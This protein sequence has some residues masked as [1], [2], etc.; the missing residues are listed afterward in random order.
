MSSPRMISDVPADRE[1]IGRAHGRGTGDVDVL[2]PVIGPC[3]L[4]A[5]G[6]DAEVID[7][8]EVLVLDAGA[9]REVIGE[10]RRPFDS[11]LHHRVASPGD[12]SRRVDHRCIAEQVMAI[13]RSQ[14][15]AIRRQESSARAGGTSH[16]SP[17]PSRPSSCCRPT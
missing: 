9:D 6:T 12:R 14:R 2:Q 13:A 17:R 4:V 8:G 3:A 10:E 15:R 5:V 1:P 11:R 16:P 7:L